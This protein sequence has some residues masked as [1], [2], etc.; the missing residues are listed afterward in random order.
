MTLDTL[1]DYWCT[2]PKHKINLHIGKE[3]VELALSYYGTFS[4][5]DSYCGDFHLVSCGSSVEEVVNMTHRK[6][7][8][9]AMR[10][11]V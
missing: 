11:A 10:E 9:F 5:C 7:M 3:S 8:L 6:L 1:A 2:S 4:F